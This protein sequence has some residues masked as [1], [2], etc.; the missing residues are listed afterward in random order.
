M[1]NPVNFKEQNI[2]Y[3]KPE[4]M[5]DEECSSLPAYADGEVIISCWQLSKEE[6]SEVVNTGVIWAGLYG[7]QV[8]MWVTGVKPFAE[9][10]I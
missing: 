2:T 10:E 1:A 4:S 8:P 5:T 9:K 3:T 6:I 7:T